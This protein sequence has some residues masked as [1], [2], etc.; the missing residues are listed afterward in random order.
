MRR[1][2]TERLALRPPCREDL[3]AFLSYRNDAVSMS[4]Q[5]LDPI[6]ETAALGFLSDQARVLDD[7][8][9]WIMFALE[10]RE[11]Q[12]MIGEVGIF[13]SERTPY[14]GDLGWSVR[15]EYQ[16]RGL[17]TEAAQALMR[18][19][20]VSRKLHRVTAS[21]N[22]KNVASRRV[23][24]RLNMRFEGVAVES[25]EWGGDWIDES[26]YALLEWEWRETNAAL[27]LARDRDQS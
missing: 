20:F 13:I 22:A 24:E 14:Q 7:A 8:V 15:R 3:T 9:G 12:Q 11:T 25:T 16:S 27:L 19:A 6:S 10:L 2:E 23:M 5:H 18:F 4:L 26:S 17:A 1:I 21:C